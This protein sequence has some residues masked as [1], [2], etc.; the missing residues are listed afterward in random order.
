MKEERGLRV[1]GNIIPRKVFGPKKDELSE[2]WKRLNNEALYD[3]YSSPNI[4]RVTTSRKMRWAVHVACTVRG[5][6][7]TAFW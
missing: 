3:V 6:T 1:L 5:D 2:E 4:T 7:N